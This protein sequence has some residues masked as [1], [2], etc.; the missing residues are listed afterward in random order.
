MN[1][2]I[3]T[4]GKTIWFEDKIRK[5]GVKS[6]GMKCAEVL[7]RQICALIS[8]NGKVYLGKFSKEEGSIE[9]LKRNECKDKNMLTFFIGEGR[10]HFENVPDR[11]FE[12][13]NGIMFERL[14]IVA[15]TPFERGSAV[16]EFLE[17]IFAWEF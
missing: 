12:N 8:I 4:F 5:E 11:K 17:K 10:L 3:Y 14:E 13:I 9:F 16:A 6:I 1:K 2:K 15:G 7:N